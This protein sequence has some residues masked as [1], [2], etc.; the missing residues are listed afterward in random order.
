[1]YRHVPENDQPEDYDTV[2]KVMI[3]TLRK[4]LDAVGL[5]AKKVIS[6]QHGHGY[7]LVVPDRAPGS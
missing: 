3:F 2:L 7:A 6:N 4:K 1:M 5:D